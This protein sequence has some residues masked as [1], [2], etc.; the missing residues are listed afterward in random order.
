MDILSEITFLQLHLRAA[1][2][3]NFRPYIRRYTSANE[4][5][6]YS[7]PLNNIL[8]RN[9]KDIISVSRYE[10][11]ILNY[12]IFVINASKQKVLEIA[13]PTSPST[14]FFSQFMLNLFCVSGSLTFKVL[15]PN[16]SDMKSSAN[17]LVLDQTALIESDP[18][19][20]GLVSSVSY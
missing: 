6:E 17:K 9:W 10:H 5:Y 7:Y 4:N 8:R 13:W 15:K 14:I 20:L 18:E 16:N 11:E 12:D 2:K 3:L 19:L 1:V